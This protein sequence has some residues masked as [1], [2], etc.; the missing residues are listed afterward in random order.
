MSENL[1]EAKIKFCSA[2]GERLPEDVIYCSACGAKSKEGKGVEPT[3]VVNN[4]TV[5]QNNMGLRPLK[6]K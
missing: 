1:N 4:T 5:V 3:V 2:C 6:D